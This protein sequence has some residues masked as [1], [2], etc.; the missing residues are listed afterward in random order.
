MKIIMNELKRKPSPLEDSSCNVLINKIKK[1]T[2]A[3]E[4][5]T[6][7]PIPLPD[8][9]LFFLTQPLIKVIKPKM[10]QTKPEMTSNMRAMFKYKTIC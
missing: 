2:K 10:V 9:S 8:L 1:R 5:K 3:I 4:P 6:V 7:K